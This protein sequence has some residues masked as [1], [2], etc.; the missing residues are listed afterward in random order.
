MSEKLEELN[1]NENALFVYWG[2]QI[3]E[4]NDELNDLQREKISV[5]YEEHGMAYIGKINFN[6]DER[7]TPSLENVFKKYNGEM[8][9]N[10]GADFII[11]T[12]DPALAGMIVEWNS[13]PPTPVK[14]IDNIFERI[15]ELGGVNL[16]WS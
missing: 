12:D 1:K 15:N 13:K 5:F 4:A 9:Y 3:P 2:G 6:G 11:L 10:F 7:E 14:L 16:I 8:V